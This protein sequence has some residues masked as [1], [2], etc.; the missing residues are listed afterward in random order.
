MQYVGSFSSIFLMEPV[1]AND[2]SAGPSY[3]PITPRASRTPRTQSSPYFLAGR[4]RR[5]VRR[6]K[7]N[8]AV[9]QFREEMRHEV[10]WAQQ[11]VEPEQY[12]IDERTIG[13]HG[14]CFGGQV[15]TTASLRKSRELTKAQTQATPE[16][17]AMVEAADLKEW[18]QFLEFEAVEA[19][20][21]EDS[22]KQAHEVLGMRYVA[23]ATRRS[24]RRQ[25]RSWL[26][27]GNT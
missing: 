24:G 19:M 3:G 14:V 13:R 15:M 21:E 16:L 11:V 26:T 2:A 20:S 9:E 4:R 22:Q 25:I 6:R 5:P 8:H 18:S 27:R 17:K 10:F 1:A 12:E 23:T 7:V